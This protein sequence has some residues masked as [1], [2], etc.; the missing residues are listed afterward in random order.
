MLRIVTLNLGS[1]TEHHPSREKRMQSL[2]AQLNKVN[3]HI[4]AFQSVSVHP[5][6]FG[7]KDQAFH[8]YQALDGF[9]SHFFQESQT[10]ADGVKRGSA[11]LSKFPM[12]EKFHQ[13]LTFTPGDN[14]QE[15]ILRATFERP[16]GKFHFYNGHFPA[17]QQ[18][19]RTSI[20]ETTSFILRGAPVPSILAANTNAIFTPELF[21]SLDKAGLRD[22]SQHLR[23]ERSGYPIDGPDADRDFFWVSPQLTA[24]LND[25]KNLF[26]DS[27]GTDG[28]RD[29]TGLMLEL[30]IKT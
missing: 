19:A 23:K 15:V 1:F 13:R 16:G 8:I 2:I 5:H 17:H 14:N 12:H 18:E 22:V 11:I 30:N 10:Q 26:Y 7:G 27:A 4:I 6:L 9:Q 28:L 25:L 24:E 29:Q 3:P 20:E 21:A